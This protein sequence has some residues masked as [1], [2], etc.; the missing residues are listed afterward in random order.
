MIIYDPP[1]SDAS[2]GDWDDYLMSL[3]PAK[4]QSEI[5]R[6]EEFMAVRFREGFR[7]VDLL[8]I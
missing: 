8:P 5:E 2:R 1:T 7:F 4:D 6:V 3:N